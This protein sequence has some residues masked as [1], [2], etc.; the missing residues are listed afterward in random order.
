M[1]PWT[2]VVEARTDLNFVVYHI[3]YTSEF[4]QNNREEYCWFSDMLKSNCR[5]KISLFLQKMFEKDWVVIGQSS[6][7]NSLY[8]TIQKTYK[9][10]KETATAD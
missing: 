10:E 7:K 6:I 8:Y 4:I 9:D 1:V 3:D 5:V 2:I